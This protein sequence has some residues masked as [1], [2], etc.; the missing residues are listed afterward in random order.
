MTERIIILTDEAERKRW[1][2]FVAQWHSFEIMQCYEWGI[3]KKVLGWKVVRLAV[4]RD[5]A[6]V[7]GAQMLIKPL[8]LGLASIAYIPRG[9]LLHWEDIAA[10]QT[11]LP[12][13]HAAARKHRA[14]SL[15]IE[16]AIPF[17][18][19]AHR[20]LQ[21]Y[22]FRRSPFN[23]QPQCT[24]LI[25]LTPDEDTILANMH[26]TTRYNIRHSARQGVVVREATVADLDTFF[27]LIKF[28][29]TQAGFPARSYDYYRQEWDTLAPQGYLKLFLAICGD[30][31]LAARM[32]AVFGRQAATLHSG[33]F[34]V[35]R[36]LKPNELLMWASLQWAKAQGCTT[37]D[38]WGIPDEIGAN[39]CQ[40][41]PLPENQTGGLWGVYQFKR[42]F[43]GSVAY[44]VGAYDFVYSP[45]LYEL[46]NTAMAQLGSLEK[47]AQWGDRLDLKSNQPAGM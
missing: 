44:S 15:K 31:V 10:A 4:E 1:N 18:L 37:Y 21:A 2:A 34:D 5:G 13:L 35:H 11:L 36:N 19:E 30:E 45:L 33:S 32:P 17:S 41:Q 40:G 14:I 20:Q 24:M 29:A 12:A 9:P 46:M 28:T 47:L 25:D 26:K 42:G 23:N 38:V 6:W 27:R 39:L 16:P 22:G 43:G 7:A 3:F 8:P